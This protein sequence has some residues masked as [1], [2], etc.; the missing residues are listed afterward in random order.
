MDQEA[1]DNWCHWWG[2][3]ARTPRAPRN[4]D[5]RQQ[6]NQH[7]H[8]QGKGDRKGYKG[9]YHPYC[10]GQKGGGKKGGK[11]GG[12]LWPNATPPGFGKGFETTTS[13]H[14]WA[15]GNIITLK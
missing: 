3:Q 8:A 5:W 15:P 14:F 6:S 9:G 7:A 12:K 1:F 11:K 10:K 2:E 13:N 4:R